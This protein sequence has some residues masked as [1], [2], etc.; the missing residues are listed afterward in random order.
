MQKLYTFAGFVFDL[1]LYSSDVPDYTGLSRPKK[2]S[3]QVQST[4]VPR[5]ASSIANHNACF[6]THWI[7][8]IAKRG[9]KRCITWLDSVLQIVHVKSE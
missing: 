5:Y 9:T 2:S 8:N 1:F 6:I 4:R 3:T 7:L